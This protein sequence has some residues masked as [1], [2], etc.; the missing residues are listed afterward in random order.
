V[1]ECEELNRERLQRER[2]D[3]EKAKE[4]RR[5]AALS[6]EEQEAES[7][8]E[9]FIEEEVEKLLKTVRNGTTTK[10]K[11]KEIKMKEV[12]KVK[13]N[14]KNRDILKAIKDEAW[15]PTS[16]LTGFG[17]D[18]IDEILGNGWLIDL[19][20][21]CN[22]HSNGINDILKTLDCTREELQEVFDWYNSGPYARAAKKYNRN[23]KEEYEELRQGIR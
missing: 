16:N 18:G 1:A 7:W 14:K 20:C 13:W 6:R 19:Q 4:A 17:C 9:L 10:A 22:D 5:W 15:E 12:K 3:E 8:R 23:R 11:H 21:G 2:D